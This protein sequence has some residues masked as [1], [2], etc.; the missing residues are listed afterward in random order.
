VLDRS[1]AATDAG[2]IKE[3]KVEATV[4]GGRPV[5]ES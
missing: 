1:L 3:I 4:V 5:Y 2:G